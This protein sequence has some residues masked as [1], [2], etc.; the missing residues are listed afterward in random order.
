MKTWHLAQLPHVLWHQKPL[1]GLPRC[2][3][4]APAQQ[5]CL[6][7]H[8]ADVCEAQR[9][10]R[11]S[12]P[13]VPHKLG[14]GVGGGVRAGEGAREVRCLA[15]VVRVVERVLLQRGPEGQALRC[16]CRV[17]AGPVLQG[18]ARGA[19][20]LSTS[21]GCW[22]N[23]ATTFARHSSPAASL[24]G[25]YT[26]ACTAPMQAQVHAPA[27]GVIQTCSWMS[28]HWES[29]TRYTAC[30]PGSVHFL[31]TRVASSTPAVPPAAT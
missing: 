19:G 13:G 30:P 11:L 15:V 18:A 6:Q 23:V 20:R 2:R 9:A 21:A 24:E 17:G 27:H 4:V 10:Q 16:S 5:T 28:T 8:R 31:R 3:A 25:G 7:Q 12:Q 26:P 1:H 29:T 22:G 14:R